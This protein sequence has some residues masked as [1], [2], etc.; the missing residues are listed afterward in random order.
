MPVSR[1]V[2]L[3][4]PRAIGWEAAAKC[5]DALRGTALEA[6]EVRSVQKAHLERIYG[7]RLKRRAAIEAIG[8]S[9]RLLADLSSY[10]GEMVSM[11]VLEGRDGQVYCMLLDDSGSQLVACFVA[12]DKRVVT[13][14]GAS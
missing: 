11:G 8:G 3:V 12:W 14:V 4:C 1:L 5:C 2:D 13:A 10:H 6:L 9:E 7:I